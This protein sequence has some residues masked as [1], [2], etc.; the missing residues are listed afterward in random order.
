M[1]YPIPE[2]E[3]KRIKSLYSYQIL[4]TYREETYDDISEM[5]AW[6]S[7]CPV[8]YIGL[9]DQKRQW[10]KSSYRLPN[11]YFDIPRELTFCAYTILENDAVV[12]ENTLENERFKNHPSVTGEAHIRFYCGI[13]LINKDKFAIGTLCVLGF[14]PRTISDETIDL[15]KKISQLVMYQLELH[16]SLS[17]LNELKKDQEIEKTKY[18]DLLL[19]ILPESVADELKKNKKVLPKYKESATLIFAKFNDKN[20]GAKEPI[21]MVED[22]N[23]YVSAYDEINSRL[24]IEKIKT[25]GNVYMAA[26][27]VPDVDRA[28]IFKSCISALNLKHY[29]TKINNHKKKIH[30]VSCELS[31]GIYS[32]PVITGV[33]GKSKFTY[34]L[35]GDSVN[36]AKRILESSENDEIL[37]SEQ[38]AFKAKEYFEFQEKGV[39]EVKHMPP[40]KMHYLKRLKPEYSQD[41]FGFLP[42]ESMARV[43]DS[44]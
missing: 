36:C 2:N 14:E 20:D 7:G 42:N 35:W 34:D 6:L 8:A 1:N 10:L 5:A 43:L 13:P 15:L 28:H 38:I 32:G 23:L 11:Q 30:M 17:I 18:N 33:V 21:R 3:E 26:C 31:I 27:G 22:L 39:G 4:D 19:N 40:I 44:F 24:D 37:V 41:S 29:M 16:K 9:M 25:V 12:I